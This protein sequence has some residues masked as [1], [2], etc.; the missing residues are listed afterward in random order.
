MFLPSVLKTKFQAHTEQANDLYIFGQQ[1]ER[2]KI[3]GLRFAEIP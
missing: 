3:L 1:N 2:Q